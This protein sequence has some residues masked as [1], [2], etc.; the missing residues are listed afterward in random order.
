MTY[1]RDQYLGYPSVAD[2]SVNVNADENAEKLIDSIDI[3]GK[4]VRTVIV[5]KS[6]AA[7]GD[8]AAEDVLS[9]SATAGTAYIFSDLARDAFGSGMIEKASIFC[10][11]TALTP[12][13]TVYLFRELPTS[14]L[15][16]NVA[17][18]APSEA[19]HM[20][21]EGQLDFMALEDLGGGSATVI[22]PN[23]AGGCPHPYRT[24]RDNR[25]YGIAVLRDA[26]TGEAA[27]MRLAISLQV[28]ID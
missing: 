4:I 3:I 14:N 8:Y 23:T 22:T 13:I 16:D 6:L 9:E 27:G 12:R 2:R 7:A 15:N 21:W 20:E 26:V 28:R 18:A 25:L 24:G 10:S 19:D 11:V 17:N 1:S 5:P